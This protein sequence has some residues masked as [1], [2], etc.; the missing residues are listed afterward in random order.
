MTRKSRNLVLGPLDKTRARR[1]SEQ[2]AEAEARGDLD[3]AVTLL[4]E[5]K[6]KGGSVDV[7]LRRLRKL[8]A[9]SRSEA[10][11]RRVEELL[12][13]REG[14]LAWTRLTVPER[15]QLSSPRLKRLE[16]LCVATRWKE[17][18][19][20]VD[21]LCALEHEGTLEERRARIV[22]HRRFL[23]RTPLGAELEAIERQLRAGERPSPEPTPEPRVGI[24]LEDLALGWEDGL[25]AAGLAEEL[26]CSEAEVMAAQR[27]FGLEAPPSTPE[28]RLELLLRCGWTRRDAEAQ[29]AAKGGS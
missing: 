25:D 24:T 6:F 18:E 17:P 5:A 10:S 23:A 26:G 21:A 3:R 2:A 15:R 16:E 4:E 27:A 9:R 19:D 7:E 11:V 13:S 14:L 12:P 1:L 8:V 29:V 22:P 20:A 28:E